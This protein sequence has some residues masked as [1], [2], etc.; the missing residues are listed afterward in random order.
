MMNLKSRAKSGVKWTSFSAV[1]GTAFQLLLLAILARLLKK[2]DF[3]LASLASFVIGFTQLFLDMGISNAIIHKQ[4]ITEK[5][6]SSL[7]WL[8]IILGVLFFFILLVLAHYFALFYEEPKLE[9]VI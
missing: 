9:D 8:N 4:S 2:E 3:G 1:I 7:Y 6:L 5:Q